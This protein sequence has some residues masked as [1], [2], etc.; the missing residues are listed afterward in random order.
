MID[1]FVPFET[2]LSSF[3]PFSSPRSPRL[4]ARVASARERQGVL[5]SPGGRVAHGVKTT[6]EFSSLYGS[7]IRIESGTR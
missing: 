4:T 1:P 6:P 2:T 7:G 3:F 5:V